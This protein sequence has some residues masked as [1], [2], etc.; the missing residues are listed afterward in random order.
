[1]ECLRSLYGLETN[2]EKA[3]ET[4]EVLLGFYQKGSRR[5]R[6][7]VEPGAGLGQDSQDN[8]VVTISKM[9]ES[10]TKN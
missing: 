5:M 10:A 1:M 9:V 4:P 3:R 8:Y 6:A 7:L 2:G